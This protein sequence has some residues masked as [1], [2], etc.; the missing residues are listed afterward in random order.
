MSKATETKRIKD[1]EKEVYRLLSKV[2]SYNEVVTEFSSNIEQ[3]RDLELE[4]VHKLS[5][6]HS[7]LE[8]LISNYSVLGVILYSSFVILATLIIYS[9]L[10]GCK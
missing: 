4:I 5:S 9:L 1:L 2:D 6:V 10:E 7:K 8:S 3:I